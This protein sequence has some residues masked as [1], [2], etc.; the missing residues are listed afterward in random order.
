MEKLTS[1][2]NSGNTLIV[3]DDSDNR[4]FIALIKLLDNDLLERYGDQQAFFDQFNKVDTIKNIVVAYINDRP[5]GCGAIKRYKSDS[6]EI[7]RMFVMN[8]HRGKG[9]AKRILAELESWAIELNSDKCI[10]ETGKSQPEAIYLYQKV[11]YS[12]INNYEPYIGVE[13]SVCMEKVLR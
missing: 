1:Q 4:D 3:R 13:N 2:P 5:V 10:L 9:I 8:G 12:I 6:M 11:G 7:K